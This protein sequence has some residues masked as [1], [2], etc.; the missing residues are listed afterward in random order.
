MR[1]PPLQLLLLQDSWCTEVK[2]RLEAETCSAIQY[3]LQGS[4][5]NHWELLGTTGNY[6]EPL[7]TPGNQCAGVSWTKMQRR[8]WVGKRLLAM[9][10]S[11]AGAA[12]RPSLQWAGGWILNSSWSP[13][14]R[15]ELKPTGCPLLTLM[16]RA[17]GCIIP[18]LM[19]APPNKYQKHPLISSGKTKTYLQLKFTHS[20]K[21]I[22][23]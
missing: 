10:V 6:W 14:T 17:F 2:L 1:P 11:Q 12:D 22:F 16:N 23:T 9:E 15:P 20:C 19:K 3:E 7:R 21:M 18:F 4:I 8:E 5:G 13:L